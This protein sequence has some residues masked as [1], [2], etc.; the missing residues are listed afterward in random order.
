MLPSMFFGQRH[1]RILAAV[2]IVL[3]IT[4]LLVPHPYNASHAVGFL[5]KPGKPNGVIFML[6]SPSR[7][8]QAARALRQAE[9]RFNRRLKY[10]YVLFTIQSELDAVGGIPEDTIRKIDWITEGRASFRA[11]PFLS[12]LHLRSPLC[13]ENVPPEHW[14]VPAT[15]DSSLVAASIKN[16]GYTLSP[17]HISPPLIQRGSWQFLGRLSINVPFLFRYASPIVQVPTDRT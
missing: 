17:C 2:A 7:L 14:D 6:V 9:D 13:T 5:R 12:F 15:L 11:T 4:A 16:I 3:F 10:P 8:M 1:G